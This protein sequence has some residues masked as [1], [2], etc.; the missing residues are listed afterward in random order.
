[1]TPRVRGST[2]FRPSTSA[3]ADVPYYSGMWTKHSQSF[4]PECG[5]TTKHVTHF[6]KDDAGSLVA[7]VRCVECPEP[8]ETAA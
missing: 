2:Y 8:S 1:M 7:E 4:C 5:R 6:L 3:G